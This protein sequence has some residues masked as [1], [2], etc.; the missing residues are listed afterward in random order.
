MPNTFKKPK[1]RVFAVSS[2]Q[3]LVPSWGEFECVIREAFTAEAEEDTVER[4]IASLVNKIRTG[5]GLTPEVSLSN[6]LKFIWKVIEGSTPTYHHLN[7]CMHCEAVFAALLDAHNRAQSKSS[8]DTDAD[9]ET[10]AKFSKVLGLACLDVK[11]FIHIFPDLA[12]RY[13]S[14]FQIVLPCVLGAFQSS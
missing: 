11:C 5:D 10:L 4:I 2:K 3:Y 13:D 7:L 8:A 6:P 9:L 14:S 1:I 12:A